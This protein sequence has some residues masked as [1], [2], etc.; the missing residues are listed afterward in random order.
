VSVRR[1]A[2]A[3]LARL[4][5]NLS[6]AAG[7]GGGTTLPGSIYLRLAPAE[8]AGLADGLPEGIVAISAT[9]GKTTTAAMVSHILEPERSVCRNG[10]GANLMSGIVTTLLTQPPAAR[11]GVLEVDEAALPSVVEAFGPRVLALG[12]LF[13]DQLD[14]HGELE[15]IADRWRALTAG[16]DAGTTL[17]LGADDPVIDALGAEH[18]NVLRYG[19][20][21]PAVALAERDEAADSTFCVR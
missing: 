9:N 3:D 18:P 5:G 2:A 8:L 11:V 13:R 16:L 1:R 7:R 14:R 12:N 15:L 17:V 4:A 20:D 21:D 10:A 6:R 19:I